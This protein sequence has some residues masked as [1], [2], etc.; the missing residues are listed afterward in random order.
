MP[1]KPRIHYPGAVYH[2]IARGN[3]QENILVSDQDKKR[4]RELIK[5]YKDR[6]SFLLYGYVIMDNHVHLI[7]EVQEYPLSKIMQ[8]IQQSY[9]QWYNQCNKRVGHVF[10]QRYKAILCDK[11][12]Y[13]LSLLK[14][15]HY[16]P[17]RAGITPTLDYPWSSHLDYLF[18]KNT[19]VDSHFCLSLFNDQAATA[20]IQYM[21]F[22]EHLENLEIIKHTS[23]NDEA[24]QMPFKNKVRDTLKLNASMEELVKIVIKKIG[25]QEEILLGSKSR[26]R[27]ILLA[28]NII[29]YLA[30]KHEIAQKASLMEY[31]NITPYQVSRGYYGAGQD[32]SLSIIRVIEEEMQ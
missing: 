23:S 5:K 2:V 18:G 13:L 6:F 8:G 7:L 29:I 16:N 14:Y 21:E 17:I 32:E 11:D 22:M 26:N 20:I 1:R 30:I 10:Q 4:Y 3:N 27:K 9:T 19:F 15:I 25:V 24:L 31:L 12:S 28:R